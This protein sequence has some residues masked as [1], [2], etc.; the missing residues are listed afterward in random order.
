M[1]KQDI[2]EGALKARLKASAQDRLYKF[3][4]ADGMMRGAVVNATQMIGEMRAN[5][6]LG[7]VETLLLGQAYIAA[8]LLT[9]ALKGK[10]RVSLHMECSGA[11][12]EPAHLSLYS[13]KSGE[14]K[15]APPG[16]VLHN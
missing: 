3:I 9:S 15:S 7:P 1:I 12:K 5:H 6:G 16:L 4:F 2:Y 8:A 14:W 11:V 10:D 13:G